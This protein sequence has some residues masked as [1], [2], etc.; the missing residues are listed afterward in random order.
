MF[1]RTPRDM[2]PRKLKIGFS[3]LLVGLI[4]GGGIAVS[5]LKM[6]GMMGH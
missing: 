3:V 5:M 4:V 6:G 2:R 1:P